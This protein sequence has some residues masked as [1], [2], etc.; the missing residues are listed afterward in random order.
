MIINTSIYLQKN[1]SGS[2]QLNTYISYLQR[3]MIDVRLHCKK[4]TPTS[5]NSPINQSKKLTIT[6]NE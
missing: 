3:F 2:S 6:I 1:V 4:I 5:N